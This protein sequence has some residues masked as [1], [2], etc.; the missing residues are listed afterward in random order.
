MELSELGYLTTNNGSYY[1]PIPPGLISA[2]S[3]NELQMYATLLCYRVAY[4]DE[5]EEKMH[6]YSVSYAT[7]KD[8][9]LHLGIGEKAVIAA[10]NKLISRGLIS[11]I[12]LD[13]ARYFVFNDAENFTSTLNLANTRKAA[14]LAPSAV[15]SKKFYT[16]CRKYFSENE[17]R[18]ADELQLQRQT[19]SET[20]PEDNASSELVCEAN[21][22]SFDKG[23][24]ACVRFNKSQNESTTLAEPERHSEVE[25]SGFPS[26]LNQNSSGPQGTTPPYSPPSVNTSELEQIDSSSLG[27]KGSDRPVVSDSRLNKG[28]ERVL[29]GDEKT[30][31]K[32]IL[33]YFES[34]YLEKYGQKIISQQDLSQRNLGI[35]RKTI[36]YQFPPAQWAKVIGALVNNYEDLPLDRSK[37]PRPTPRGM[38]Q[39]WLLSLVAAYIDNTTKMSEHE[40]ATREE[41]KL[42]EI[43]AELPHW[44]K[45]FYRCVRSTLGHEYEDMVDDLIDKN[46]L[47]GC[48]WFNDTSVPPEKLKELI[49]SAW[50]SL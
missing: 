20:E 32:D 46:R 39:K 27:V 26:T 8:L 38:T 3:A 42:A 16:K 40:L 48:T 17:T 13:G 36:M 7:N 4:Q 28:V 47:N 14:H 43:K 1:A 11:K 30:G 22:N 29:N 41:Q 6:F 10:V 31:P 9:A 49:T 45:E 25:K 24:Y 50:N 18:S 37:Y 15:A 23:A 34:L 21:Q 44:N 35:L 2:L 12:H 19:S 5:N 33:R